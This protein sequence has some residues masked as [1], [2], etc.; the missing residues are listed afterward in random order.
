MPTRILNVKDPAEALEKRDHLFQTS[1][2]GAPGGATGAFKTRSRSSRRWKRMMKSS[3]DMATHRDRLLSNAELDGEVL[4]NLCRGHRWSHSSHC[5][6]QSQ[7]EGVLRSL[8]LRRARENDELT[9][10]PSRNAPPART[11]KRP[12]VL[13]RRWRRRSSAVTEGRL[14]LL[15]RWRRRR[16]R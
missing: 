10:G 4:P 13:H 1:Q 7:R 16:W 2:I 11:R 3:R 6:D 9:K 14:G 8:Q 5:S 12:L 15:Q